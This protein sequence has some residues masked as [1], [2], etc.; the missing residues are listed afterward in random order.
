[1]NK[2]SL[3]EDGKFMLKTNSTLWE[4]GCS[5]DHGCG[6][7]RRFFGGWELLI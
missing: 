4:H 3:G 5:M 2:R 1:M 7:L 6:G